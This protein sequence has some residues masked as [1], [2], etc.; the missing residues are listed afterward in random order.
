MNAVMEIKE[1]KISIIIHY[2]ARGDD[3]AFPQSR[4]VFKYLCVCVLL[5]QH[6]FAYFSFFCCSAAAFTWSVLI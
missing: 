4:N 1:G 2:C 3:A 6:I 5:E